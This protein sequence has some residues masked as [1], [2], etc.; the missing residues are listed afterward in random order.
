MK[1]SMT[2]SSGALHGPSVPQTVVL[3]IIVKF[4]AHFFVNFLS[5]SM[6]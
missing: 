1:S 3:M 5:G 4:S 2:S 6:P